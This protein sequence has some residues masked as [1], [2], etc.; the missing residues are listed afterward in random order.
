[1]SC[2]ELRN[3]Q[4]YLDGELTGAE[5]A[6]AERHLQSCAEC[7]AFAASAADLSDGL[8]QASRHTAPAHLRAA[9]LARLDKEPSRFSPRSFWMG[10]AGGAGV[11]AL[12]AGFALLALL[13]PSIATLTRS[14]A[15]AHA[16]ALT[17][18]KTIMVASSNHHTV[19]PWLAAHAGLSPPVSDFAADGFTLTGGRVD[20]VAGRPA[21]VMVYRHGN[22]ELDL[23]AWPDRGADLPGAGMAHGFRTSFWKAGD[24]D[25]AAVSDVDQ[26]AFQKFVGLARAQRE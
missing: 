1:M 17:G 4:S 26:A 10:A 20:E 2:E 13:P 23:F 7:Q 15:D 25:F 24:L 16:R 11:S 22:H 8:R 18:G 3:T 12:A 5:A 19:K 21:A 9:I 14:V 6:E